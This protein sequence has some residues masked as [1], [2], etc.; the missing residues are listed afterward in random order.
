MI[1]RLSCDLLYVSRTNRTVGRIHW[2]QRNVTMSVMCQNPQK[3][4]STRWRCESMTS[5]VQISKYILLLTV[6][7][8]C[9]LT[10][11]PVSFTMIVGE[12]FLRLSD[13]SISRFVLSLAPTSSDESLLTFVEHSLIEATMEMLDDLFGTYSAKLHFALLNA[14]LVGTPPGL[15]THQIEDS[16]KQT[17][18][19]ETIL[20]HILVPSEGYI[21]HL[22]AN[23]WSIVDDDQ[24]YKRSSTP[25][26]QSCHASAHSRRPSQSHAQPGEHDQ[27]P[28][29]RLARHARPVSGALAGAAD[30]GLQQVDEAHIPQRQ[31]NQQTGMECQRALTDLVHLGLRIFLCIVISPSFPICLS[32]K[33]SRLMSD[34]ISPTSTKSD[35]SPSAFVNWD[36]TPIDSHSDK[37]VIFYSLVSI[38]KSDEMIDDVMEN[39]IILFLAQ[40]TAA[41]GDEADQLIFGL[42]PPSTGSIDIFIASVIVL[43]SVSNQKIIKATMTMVTRLINSCSSELHLKLVEGDLIVVL[44]TRSGP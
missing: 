6:R 27:A 39:N 17:S 14:E 43:T 31:L 28:H 20:K 15:K 37:V 3:H 34:C 26:L 32:L 42:V 12:N 4:D 30:R 44:E 36:G 41:H 22:C 11:L 10:K 2:K 5:S 24:L 21:H 29:H 38:L 13:E 19:N 18:V 1:H 16:I 23:R 35:H 40:I 7:K 25:L 9:G 8:F 33:L